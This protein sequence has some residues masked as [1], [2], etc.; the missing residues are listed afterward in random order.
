[1]D[2]QQNKE[3]C[4]ICGKVFKLGDKLFKITTLTREM[5]T[6]YKCFIQNIDPSSVI[7]ATIN[8]KI[9]NNCNTKA[10]KSKS[11][12]VNINVDI[13]S[14]SQMSLDSI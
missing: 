13:A 7:Y 3:K 6:K 1:M 10:Y 11:K 4:Y 5:Y 2:T 14:S 8:D 12:Y 9:C